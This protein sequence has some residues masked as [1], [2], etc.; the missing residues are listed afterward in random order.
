MQG[1]LYLYG[2]IKRIG[3]KGHNMRNRRKKMSAAIDVCR[4]RCL[5]Q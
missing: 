1:A 3:H 4:N 5:P 2:Q